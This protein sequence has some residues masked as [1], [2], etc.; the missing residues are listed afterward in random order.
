MCVWP[1]GGRGKKGGRDHFRGY[2]TLFHILYCC[3][4]ARQWEVGGS[5]THTHIGWVDLMRCPRS[6]ARARVI[7]LFE[8]GSTHNHPKPTISSILFYVY[9][10]I[11]AVSFRTK[12]PCHLLEHSTCVR[13]FILACNVFASSATNIALRIHT[14]RIRNDKSLTEFLGFS[15]DG[16]LTN[17]FHAARARSRI[18][19][20]ELAPMTCWT[21]AGAQYIR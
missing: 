2:Y 8:R 11:V 17:N 15:A 1:V 16:N 21:V 6:R 19:I 18:P 4:T 12:F 14:V 20:V 10:E 9:K 7:I 3:T 5:D 13:E